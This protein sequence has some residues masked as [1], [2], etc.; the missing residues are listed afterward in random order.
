MG[1]VKMLIDVNSLRIVEINTNDNTSA[2]V[3]KLGVLSELS[4]SIALT[5]STKMFWPDADV[6]FAATYE[7]GFR[8]TF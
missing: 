7:L 4:E 2:F 5:F 3:L 1:N 8:Y 6:S